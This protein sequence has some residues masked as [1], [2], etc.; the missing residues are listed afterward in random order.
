M[1]R[2]Y[3]VTGCGLVLASMLIVATFW[4]RG[5][6]TRAGQFGAQS[7]AALVAAH[8]ELARAGE[9]ERLLAQRLG[10]YYWP[11]YL[12]DKQAGKETA[13]DFVSENPLLPRVLIIG[14]SISRGYT[15]P[16]RRALAGQVNVLR[17]PENCGNSANG[18]KLLDIWL[19]HNPRY[20]LIVVNF[21]IHDRGTSLE[22]YE[23]NVKKIVMRLGDRA[24]KLIWVTTTPLPDGP[25]SV[26]DW[27]SVSQY[28]A[29]A[30]YRRGSTADQ[31]NAVATPVALDAGA[32]IVDLHELARGSKLRAH[33]VPYDVHYTE[34][35]YQHMGEAIAEAIR[36][37][38]TKPS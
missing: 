25:R 35:G 6:P 13:W 10:D 38:L 1:R 34:A 19:G 28:K 4:Y 33:R 7:P 32:R 2:A 26:A 11:I 20:D 9:W 3:A 24:K 36:M 12:R 21:G 15:L 23:R 17:A 5:E 37:E 29:I 30:I 8:S 22:E 31:L 27:L 14:D 16:V 18:L